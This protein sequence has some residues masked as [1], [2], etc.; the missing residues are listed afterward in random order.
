[1]TLETLTR[2]HAMH[3]IHQGV[4]VVQNGW[5]GTVVE[6]WPNWYRA[7]YSVEFNPQG[8]PGADVTMFGLTELDVQPD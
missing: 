1:M 3:D 4:N 5:H 6:S 8:V 2:V 7:T